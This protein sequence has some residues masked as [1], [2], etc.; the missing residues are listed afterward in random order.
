[1]GW[2]P[3]ASDLAVVGAI[4]DI[5]SAFGQS[6]E[7]EQKS[8]AYDYNANILEQN[9]ATARAKGEL[10][11][12][13][14]RKEIR[15][16]IGKQAAGYASAGVTMRGSPVDVMVESLSNAYFDIAIDKYNTEV[17]ARGYENQAKLQRYYGEQTKK[18]AKTS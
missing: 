13:Q 4:G 7:G 12:Y 14:K 2:T 11:E 5:T 16:V 1:M 6:Q 10:Q 17:A 15:S 8:E 9:A 3:S 18:A